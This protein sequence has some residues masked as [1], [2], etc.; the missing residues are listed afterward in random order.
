MIVI[1]RDGKTT[2]I[3]GWRAGLLA[4]FLFLGLSLVMAL[5]AFVFVGVAVTLGAVLLIIL[6]VVIV[7][8][9]LASMFGARRP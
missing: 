5:I 4:A 9:V 1:Q 6:P 8:A 2:T 3:T 7:M